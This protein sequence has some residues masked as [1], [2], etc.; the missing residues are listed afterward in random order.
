MIVKNCWYGNLNHLG[1]EKV[2]SVKKEDIY[3]SKVERK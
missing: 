3:D 1:T 2:W